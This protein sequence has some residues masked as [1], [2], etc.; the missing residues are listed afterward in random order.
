MR[1]GDERD[2]GDDQRS[3]A[4]V[5]QAAVAEVSTRT[6]L[7][8]AATAGRNALSRWARVDPVLRIGVPVLAV[9]LA[10]AGLFGGLDRV[11]ITEQ[12]DDVGVGV[13]IP[14]APFTLTFRGAIAANAFEGAPRP[15][16]E[17]GQLMVV[18]V[19]AENRSEAGVGSHLLVPV[20]RAKSFLD[21]N[22][23]ILDD[24]LI[25]TPPSVYEVDT[26]TGV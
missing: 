26:M 13:A 8:T 23:V 24:R 18:L 9:L 1:E 19:D 11:A 12:V 16:S 4:A 3:D 22:I 10:V 17:H 15:S 21:R 2:V 6:R 14:A 5:G 25:T 20:S 7:A